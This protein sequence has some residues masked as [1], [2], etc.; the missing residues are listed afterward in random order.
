MTSHETFKAPP[1]ADSG[2]LLPYLCRS[3]SS[4]GQII[5]WG[6]P[7]Y[8]TIAQPRARLVSLSGRSR[9][10]FISLCRFSF[11]F[12]SIARRAML[13]LV[14]SPSQ[15]LV[16]G[17][18]SQVSSSIC[19]FHFLSVHRCARAPILSLDLLLSWD[20]VLSAG[21]FPFCP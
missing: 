2:P 20:R 7:P 21:S 5:W 14:A 17:L 19:R 8:P 1:V 4:I 11:F 10:D 15:V 12:Y 6:E 16:L 13:L 18:P 9:P 3:L